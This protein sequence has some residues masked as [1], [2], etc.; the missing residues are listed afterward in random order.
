MK[1]NI[2]EPFQIWALTKEK[3]DKDYAEW[4]LNGRITVYCSNCYCIVP[5]V[6]AE[7][8]DACPQCK[9][10]IIGRRE[11]KMKKV[12]VKINTINDLN[13]F[14]QKARF[15]DGDVIVSRGKFSVD[16]KSILGVFSI[17]VSEGCFVEYPE[18]AKD[19]DDF[20]SPFV[21]N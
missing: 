1:K 16:G 5:M 4:V 21:N 19:F 13:A 6:Q 18:D 14:V 15:V 7:Y 17:D 11:K 3:K 8:L 12:C 9:A 20:L 10:Q 2:N